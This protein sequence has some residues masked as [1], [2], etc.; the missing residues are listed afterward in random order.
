MAGAGRRCTSSIHILMWNIKYVKKVVFCS[1]VWPLLPALP[2]QQTGGVRL[3]DVKLTLSRMHR[4]LFV[5]PADSENL[6]LCQGLG[7]ELLYSFCPRLREKHRELCPISLCP[8]IDALCFF[9]PSRPQ[10]LT[11]PN[12]TYTVPL[13]YLPVS[14]ST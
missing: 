10:I 7:V 2:F 5:H 1:L 9:P 14:H 4:L 13:L 11:P 8:S 6:Y 3:E 12:Q